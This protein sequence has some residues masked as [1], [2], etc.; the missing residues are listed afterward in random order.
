MRRRINKPLSDLDGTDPYIH[1]GTIRG[2]F[3][4]V[5]NA[6]VGNSRQPT[7]VQMMQIYRVV[8]SGFKNTLK[9]AG[10]KNPFN[11]AIYAFWLALPL[12]N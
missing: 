1:D 3:R 9:N 11:A 8:R 2:V 4:E 12:T 5:C 6:F 10:A 7:V